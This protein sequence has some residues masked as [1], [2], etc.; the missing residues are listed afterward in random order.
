M[1][2][3][4]SIDNQRTSWIFFI[5]NTKIIDEEVLDQFETLLIQLVNEILDVN[6]SFKH[7]PEAKWCEF[8]E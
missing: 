8:C 7:T 4:S 5:I 2:I 1:F 6:T 3:I